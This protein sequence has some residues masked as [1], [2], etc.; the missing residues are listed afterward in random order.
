MGAPVGTGAPG[1]QP[2]APAGAGVAAPAGTG[3]KFEYPEDRSNWVDPGKHKAAEKATN[4]ATQQAMRLQ[5][6]LE[7]AN[8]RIQALA[9]VHP[10]NPADAEKREIIDAFLKIFPGA[11]FLT[12]EKASQK[13]QQWLQSS[14]QA[15]EA[16]THHWETHRE[17]VYGDLK[18]AFADELNVET[19]TP[20]QTAKLI[21]AFHASVPD[22]QADPEAWDAWRQRYE[23]RDPALIEEFLK[24]YA[25]DIIEPAR[26]QAVA[27]AVSR[28]PRVPQGGPRRPPAAPPKPKID[29]GNLD[30]VMAAAAADPRM[31]GR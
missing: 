9:G 26:R 31:S 19:L 1:G 11:Q 4:L 30:Q 27:G 24:E 23:R 14:D 3:K 13:F 2:G 15:S 20:R 12:D 18:S 25:E 8:Q 16:V 28:N 5:A 22:R 29:F 10:Q 17:Q 21:A 7:Q 6:Q